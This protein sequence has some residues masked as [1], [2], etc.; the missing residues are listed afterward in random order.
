[1]WNAAFA[2][3]KCHDV[4]CNGEL[5]WDFDRE[6]KWGTCWKEALKCTK[7]NFKSVLCKLYNEA[8]IG[9][10]RG[11]K[12]AAPNLG[13]H[14]AL[15]QLPVGYAAIRTASICA[16]IPP[17][18]ATSLK[19]NA[20]RVCELI[21]KANKDDLKQQ[22]KNL[23]TINELRG[24]VPETGLA[25]EGDGLFNNPLSSGV[26]KTPFQPATQCT[27]TICENITTE[28]KVI[29]LVT[30]NKLCKLCNSTV[31]HARGDNQH[32][33]YSSD[34]SAN[35]AVDRTIGDEATWAAECL[36]DIINNDMQVNV[37]T[38]DPDSKAFSGE[39]KE[40]K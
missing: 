28:K 29:G 31:P 9:G 20:N 12:P 10:L 4:T 11:P 2:E 24:L 26:G 40:T 33:R 5:E 15:S 34:C 35:I 21:A 37:F 13:I 14:V 6:V 36:T 23:K 8:N 7:C 22:I 39:N 30:K 38:T 25:V 1:M 19:K 18:S 27:Y 32:Q 17:P 3:H 16:N